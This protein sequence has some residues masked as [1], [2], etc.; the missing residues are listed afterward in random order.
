MSEDA[1]LSL[2]LDP[3]EGLSLSKGGARQPPHRD[4]PASSPGSM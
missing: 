1:A 3:V 4:P 2:T